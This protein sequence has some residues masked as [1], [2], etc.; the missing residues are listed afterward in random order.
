MVQPLGLLLISSVSCVLQVHVVQPGYEVRI[1]YRARGTPLQGASRL[2]AHVGHSGWRDTAD[3]EMTKHL[4]VGIEAEVREGPLLGRVAGPPTCPHTSSALA[5]PHGRTQPCVRVG[6]CMHVGV[7]DPTW[8]APMS[9]LPCA[10]IAVPLAAQHQDGTHPSPSPL[11]VFQAHDGAPCHTLPLPPPTPR[12]CCARLHQVWQGTY[13]VRSGSMPAPWHLEAQMV[14]K[15]LV[16]GHERWVGGF[17]VLLVCVGRGGRGIEGLRVWLAA[18][19]GA[20]QPTNPCQLPLT[21]TAGCLVPLPLQVG[22][23]RRRQLVAGG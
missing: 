22:Q 17:R 18:N 21:P 10:R 13:V 19:Q 1:V 6:S 16:G 11:A 2:W 4:G 3:V 23:Q 8:Q 12:H 9:T 7:H 15:A 20:N 5:I 14:F